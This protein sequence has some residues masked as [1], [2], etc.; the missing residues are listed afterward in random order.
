MKDIR[1]VE[2]NANEQETLQGGGYYTSND[3]FNNVPQ[4]N[5]YANSSASVSQAQNQQ[6]QGQSLIGGLTKTLGF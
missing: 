1:F 3:E 2:L 5:N 6:Q 4:N